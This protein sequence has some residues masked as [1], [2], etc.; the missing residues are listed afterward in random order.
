MEAIARMQ[1]VIP[2]PYLR[3][4]A[5]VLGFNGKLFVSLPATKSD[6]HRARHFPIGLLTIGAG[7]YLVPRVTLLGAI[8]IRGIRL[9]RL[10][11]KPRASDDFTGKSG[12]P[13]DL[14]ARRNDLTCCE[15]EPDA[16]S[17]ALSAQ[18]AAEDLGSGV[19]RQNGSE[20]A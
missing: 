20:H 2:R 16:G 12:M 17:W 14:A 5:R 18:R 6:P 1:S 8:H 11:R 15:S 4:P 13:I 9:L 7:D 10:C 3:G 19:L